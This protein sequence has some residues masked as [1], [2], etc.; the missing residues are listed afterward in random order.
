MK[1]NNIVNLFATLAKCH[2]DKA[3]DNW[4][5]ATNLLRTVAE[6]SD[7]VKDVAECQ[8]KDPTHSM[9]R[10]DYAVWDPDHALATPAV[11]NIAN[12][13]YWKH[14]M[15]ILI[16]NP[17]TSRNV[18]LALCVERSCS[19]LTSKAARIPDIRTTHNAVLWPSPPIQST[20]HRAPADGAL[21]V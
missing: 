12:E 3:M 16:L 7:R 5:V 21:V 13:T 19:N 1:D 20:L 8:I 15:E 11:V 14:K 2:V 18:C 9:R 4:E 6:L 10:P 17:T